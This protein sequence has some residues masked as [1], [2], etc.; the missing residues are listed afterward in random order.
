VAAM[1][2]LLACVTGAQA[3]IQ[4]ELRFDGQAIDPTA[5]PDFTCYSYSLGRWVGCRIQ[6]S[7]TPGAYSLETLEPGKYQMHVSVDE[8]PANPRRFPGDYEAQVSFEITTTGPERLVVDLARLIHL[9]RPGDNARAIE[10]MLTS[11]TKQP[12]FDTPRFS[13]GPTA[14]VDFAWDPIVAGAEYRYTLFA[15]SCGQPGRGERS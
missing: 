5:K 14:T 6:K 8:N 11:C 12:Q 15:R 2:A 7:D 3:N 1:A 9:T 4:V 10:G 13:W